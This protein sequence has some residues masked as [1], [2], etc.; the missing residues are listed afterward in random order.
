MATLID[1]CQTF[2]LWHDGTDWLWQCDQCK[3]RAYFRS[4]YAAKQHANRH[5][6]GIVYRNA[7]PRMAP[8][9]D[10]AL[11]AAGEGMAHY[12]EPE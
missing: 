9:E 11:C 1:T 10:C 8:H 4:E 6:Y 3:A 5:A 2:G 12:P 7:D